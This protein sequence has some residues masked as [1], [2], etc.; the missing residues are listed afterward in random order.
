VHLSL[1]TD[2]YSR[3]FVGWHVHASL[4]AE[5]VSQALRMALR[6]RKMQLTLVHHS[7]RGVQGE[8]NPSA[9]HLLIGGVDEG[10]ETESGSR[11]ASEDAVARSATRTA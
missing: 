2:A 3:K 10:Q 5:E 6:R 11:S 8:F 1:V 4:Q 7:D 9:Q